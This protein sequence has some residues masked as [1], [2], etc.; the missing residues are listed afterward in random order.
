MNSFY[1]KTIE[2]LHEED[3]HTMINKDEALRKV[4]NNLS[5]FHSMTRQGDL[6]EVKLSK[7]SSINDYAYTYVGMLILDMS[8]RIMNEVMVLAEDLEIDMYY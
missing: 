3:L 5:N 7:I 2:R 4:E 8:K 1:G 6:Y